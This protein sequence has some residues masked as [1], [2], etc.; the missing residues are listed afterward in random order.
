MLE[1][2]T[3]VLG[4]LIICAF[5]WRFYRTWQLY[6]TTK[7]VLEKGVEAIPFHPQDL[8]D[9]IQQALLG[10]RSVQPGSFRIRALVYGLIAV[11]LLPIKGYQPVLY[12]LVVGLISFYLPWCILFGIRLSSLAPEG[13]A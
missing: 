12:W 8:N 11:L 2:N 4:I 7:T 1:T 13:G 9:F 3:L 6:L 10:R 5:G